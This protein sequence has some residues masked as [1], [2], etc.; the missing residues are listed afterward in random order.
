MS[1]EASTKSLS[2]LNYG[3]STKLRD[4]ISI[5]EHQISYRASIKPHVISHMKHRFVDRSS[6]MELI[7]LPPARTEF[8]VYAI[9]M[10]N[11]DHLPREYRHR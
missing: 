4:I 7:W 8:S 2:I 9:V 11:K 3:K 1:Y 5:A 6:P 10:A